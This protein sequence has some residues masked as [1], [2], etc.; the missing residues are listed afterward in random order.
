M[1]YYFYLFY[2]KQPWVPLP[3]PFRD[4]VGNG[5][6]GNPALAKPVLL[7]SLLKD[8]IALIFFFKA[9]SEI[10]ALFQV[11]SQNSVQRGLKGDELKSNRQAKAASVTG[12]AAGD[13]HQWSSALAAAAAMPTPTLHFPVQSSH[14]ALVA[15]TVPQTIAGEGCSSGAWPLVHAKPAALGPGPGKAELKTINLLRFT[16]HQPAFCSW[17]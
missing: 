9:K 11:P 15:Q 16:H 5:R 14:E 7:F 8:H 2:P 17:F 4:S 3:R 13:C 6:T 10:Q 1:R 12:E